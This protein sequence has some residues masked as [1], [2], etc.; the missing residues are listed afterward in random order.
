MFYS[1]KFA[2]YARSLHSGSGMAVAGPANIV[3]CTPA[4]THKKHREDKGGEPEE[5]EKGPGAEF[6]LWAGNT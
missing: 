5:R 3:T 6:I 4:R 2:M 1:I